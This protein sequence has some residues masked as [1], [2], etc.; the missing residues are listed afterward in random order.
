MLILQCCSP[1]PRVQLVPECAHRR[2]SRAGH[3]LEPASAQPLQ[4]DPCLAWEPPDFRRQL[5]T[6]LPSGFPAR[7]SG[8]WVFTMG[9]YSFSISLPHSEDLWDSVRSQGWGDPWKKRDQRQRGGFQPMGSRQ[10]WDPGELRLLSLQG[11]TNQW[12]EATGAR[13]PTP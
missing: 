3:N 2:L 8:L 10:G 9:L 1:T 11:L 5:L 12:G 6:T 4:S 7:M 13:V